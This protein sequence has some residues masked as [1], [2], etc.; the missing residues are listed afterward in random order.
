MSTSTLHTMSPGDTVNEEKPRANHTYY[1]DTGV[2]YWT[3]TFTFSVTDWQGFR[4]AN[5]GLVN[6]FLVVSMVLVMSLVGEARLT[7]L[8]K[9]YPMKEPAG[10]VTNEVRIK[11]WRITLYLL[12]E[13]YVLHPDGRGVTVDSTERFGPI[14]FLFTENKAHP[15]EVIDEG[16]RAIYYMP[17]LGDDWV[18]RYQVKENGDRIESTLRCA[19][20]EGT[21]VI[22]RVR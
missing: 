22:D 11:I 17:L 19:W 1:F 13:R 21:E 14:P 16:K 10:V 12:T 6:R 5:I 7:S 18:G 15:A 4:E 3:G 20:G 8:L 9:G 2:G